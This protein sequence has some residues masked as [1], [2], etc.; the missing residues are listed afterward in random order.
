MNEMKNLNLKL[1]KFEEKKEKS[2]TREVTKEGMKKIVP[3]FVA[4]QDVS[5]VEVTSSRATIEEFGK[6]VKDVQ[7]DVMDGY[8]MAHGFKVLDLEVREVDFFGSFLEHS[9]EDIDDEKHDD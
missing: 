9:R 2:E 8:E 3:D 1:R 5:I 4:I 7:N 6:D